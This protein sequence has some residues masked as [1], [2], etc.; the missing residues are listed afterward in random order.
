M[1]LHRRKNRRCP[2]DDGIAREADPRGEEGGTTMMADRRSPPPPP[3]DDDGGGGGAS[4][5]GAIAETTTSPPP[6]SREG[7]SVAAKEYGGADASSSSSSLSSSSSSATRRQS[8]HVARYVILRLVGFVYLVAF[9]GAYIQNAGLMGEHGLVPAM[10]RMEDLRAE[11][12]SSSS[13]MRGFISHPS[14]YWFV[15][16]PLLGDMHLLAAAGLG[17]ALSF[18]VVLGLDSWSIMVALWL[19]DFTIVTAAGGNSFYAYGWESQLLETGFLSIWLCD[20]PLSSDLPPSLP[21]LWLF[22][23]LCAR[24]SVGAGLIKLRGGEC[25]RMRTCLYYHFETQPI[26]RWVDGAC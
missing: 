7:A 5:Q 3:D 18:A 6:P 4:E 16:P 8:F 22:R 15:P 25:W 19:L 9:G 20:P 14:L 17:S 12:S 1:A 10:R 21:V 24:I 26:P 2:E 13:P 23:W 11:F